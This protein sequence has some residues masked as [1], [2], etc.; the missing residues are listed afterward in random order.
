MGVWIALFKLR[1]ALL[2]TF[3]GVAAAILTAAQWQ[4]H[5]LPGLALALMLASAGAGALNHALD[6]DIDR[7]MSRTARRPIPSGRVRRRTAI[8]AGVGLV[9]VAL[10]VAA[11]G[12]NRWVALYLF[13]G[14][15]VYVVVYTAWLKRRTAANIVVGGL[16]G[17]F[18]ALAGGA[19]VGPDLGLPPILLAAVL[20]FWTPPHFWALAI[21]CE[22]DYR[23]AGIPMLPV[24]RGP[25]RTA[26]WI[27]AHTMALVAVSLVPALLGRAA[28][29]YATA[30]AAL[31]AYYLWRNWQ[32]FRRPTRLSARRS[33]RASLVYL[34]LLLAAVVANLRL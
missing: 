24:V 2:I 31:G 23:Q 3:S 10:A 13:G 27:L 15:F 32:L 16:A 22:E 30:A 20:F 34:T 18:A 11:L 5:V 14:V 4:A 1:I 25:K 6:A 8:A 7:R 28:P 17:S 9:L 29:A 33:F 26:G 21:A 12:V 19:S